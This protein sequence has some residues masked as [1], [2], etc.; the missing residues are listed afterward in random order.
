MMNLACWF[1]IL[2]IQ[3][4]I[5]AIT[6]VDRLAPSYG[7]GSHHAAV[8]VFTWLRLGCFVGLGM[9]LGG[10]SV[11]APHSECEG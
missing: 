1:A 2:N 5:L 4:K 3:S 8:Q 6:H 7:S 9:G 10:C 11:Y